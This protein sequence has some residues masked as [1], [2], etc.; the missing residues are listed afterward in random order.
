VRRKHHFP[1]PLADTIFYGNRTQ[2][3]PSLPS[4]LL[5]KDG[6]VTDGYSSASEKAG[7]LPCFFGD[8]GFLYGYYMP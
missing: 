6:K 8:T 7:S 5:E 1:V 3:E 4:G 2:Q